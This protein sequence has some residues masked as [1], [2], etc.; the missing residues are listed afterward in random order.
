[1][2]NVDLFKAYVPTRDKKCLVRFKNRRSQDLYSL[3]DVEKMPEYAGILADETVLI[4]IDDFEESEILFRIVQD[5][6]LKCRVYETTRG[7]HFLFQNSALETCKTHT[8]LACGLSADIK[9][10]RRNSYSI[11]KFKGTNRKILYDTDDYEILPKWLN[12]VN[13][14]LDFLCMEEGDGRNQALFNYI[15]TLQS[16]DFSVSECR[17]CLGI[18]N[19]YVL[20]V[21]LSDDELKTLSRDEAFKKPVFFNGKTFLFDKFAVYLKNND[22]I[23][24]ING[25][26]HIYK[27]GIYIDAQRLI[28]SAMIDKIPNLSKAKRG[29]VLSY[30]DVMIDKDTPLSGAE[31]IA[32][33]NGVYNIKTDELIPFS[34]EIIVT[35][36]I[37][38]NYNPE[39]ECWIVDNTLKKLAVGDDEII[40]LLKEAVGYTFFRRNELRKAFM[41]TGEK[42]NG[43]STFLAMLKTLLGENNTSA[44]DLKE[45]GDRFSSASM[46]NKL[47]NIGDDIS[48]EFITNPAIFKKIVSGDRIRGE[49]KGEKEFFFEP[50]CKLFFSA[51]DIPK[52][53]DK[54]GAV[55]DRLII[56]PF[57]ARFDVKDPDY[58]P[59]IK[60]KLIQEDA[61][62]RLILLGLQGLKDVLKNQRFTLPEKSRR[63]LAEYEIG[64]NPILQFFADVE[65]ADIV[66][67]TTTG[68]YNRYCSF[69]MD[70][71]CKPISNIEF[72]RRVKK[73]YDVKI[74]R[75]TIG[76]NKFKYFE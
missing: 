4:D 32:F 55:L 59:Y 3:E 50:Y 54:T 42:K 26:L 48:D 27:D 49:L 71:F 68:V 7:K 61:L 67:Q 41:L 52:M 62:E 10:G 31:Y 60:Y 8:R 12:P 34:P 45:L 20:S 53:K 11:L 69:C 66:G 64:N 65:R 56:I 23:K 9:L 30:L 75:R 74:T 18:I 25:R 43:K 38:H 13:S 70:N 73:A 24:R 63:E 19:D 51:N 22:Y 21:P 29:E 58:D 1:M 57:N 33:K 35:N 15:L 37:N 6:K 40:Q 76:G 46:F 72:S 47:A 17:E 5:K 44:L 36:K 2:Q 16:N 28:E 14:R 39:A